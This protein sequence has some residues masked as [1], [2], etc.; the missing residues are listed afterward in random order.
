MLPEEPKPCDV[1]GIDVKG[2]DW[3]HFKE[4]NKKRC[5]PCVR[6]YMKAFWN[7]RGK[8]ACWEVHE[9]AHNEQLDLFK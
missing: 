5:M 1:C 3:M 4:D 6:K 8:Q 7:A 9:K 2:N